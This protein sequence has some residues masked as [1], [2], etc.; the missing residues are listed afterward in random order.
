[1]VEY[2][3]EYGPY[4][5]LLV[6]ALI[7]YLTRMLD[8]TAILVAIFF[9]SIILYS[10]GADYLLI[11]VLFLVIGSL[12]T[13]LKYDYK[14]S[15]GASEPHGG[16]RSINPV[17]ANGI[18]PTFMA[19]LGNPYLLVGSLSAALADTMA[20]EI[21]LLH[22]NPVLV[23]T[24]EVVEAGTRGA[25]SILGE[26]AAILGALIIAL[27]SILLT[28]GSD[29]HIMA[30]ALISGLIGCNID[31]LLGASMEFLSK[32]EVNLLGTLSGAAISA[33]IALSF[34]LPV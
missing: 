25:I 15:I 9:G 34:A 33:G 19:V 3:V 27:L 4:I 31:S 30:I 24:G 26:I 23:T 14:K 6:F 16:R 18:V 5:A 22:K 11:L 1:M 20:T 17:I 7:A 29:V 12:F 2:L 13:R 8:L 21:G 32:E 28:D 10:A